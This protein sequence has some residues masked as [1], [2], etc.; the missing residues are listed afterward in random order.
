MQMSLVEEEKDQIVWNHPA[1]VFL[2]QQKV[3]S[4]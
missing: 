4:F 1:E 3:D 2:L